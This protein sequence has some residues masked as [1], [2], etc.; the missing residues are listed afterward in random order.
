ML[1]KK[2]S[3]LLAFLIR[4]I[5]VGYGWWHDR[6]FIVKYTDVDYQVFSDAAE[7]VSLGKSPYERATYRYTPLLSYFMLPNIYLHLD[8]GKILFCLIDLLVGYI[9]LQLLDFIFLNYY[10]KKQDVEK[11]ENN[12][13]LLVNLTILF[14]PIIINV[15]TRGNADQIVVL[16]VLLTLYYSLIKKNLFLSAFW[17]G[18]SVHFKIYPIIYLPT[19][20]VYLWCYDKKQG[21]NKWIKCFNYCL[22][23]GMTC[24]L[25]I[26]VFYLIYGYEFLF[27]TYLYHLVRSDNRHNF[28]IYFYYLYLSGALE[29]STIM[30]ILAFLPQT[31]SWLCIGWNVKEITLLHSLFLQTFVFVAFN[32]VCT[33]QY[34]VWY[35]ALFGF[36]L[37]HYFYQRM[38]D[39]SRKYALI[40][41]AFWVIL[42]FLGQAIW[43]STA[44]RLEFLGENTFFSLWMASVLFFT[45]NSGIVLYF[46]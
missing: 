41:L 38:K 2:T 19:L 21:E 8:F 31:L 25:L 28:S 43:L 4:M 46:M 12:S 37:Q 6:N 39:K 42:W 44:Y 26:F 32:K 34:F 9:V 23:S 11:I 40:M 17:F 22:V 24:I 16:F 30:S 15:S 20:I 14:N 27:E 18:L 13:L 1:N 29:K 10:V 45:I 7:F 35:I 33:V 36:T 3:F 5:V